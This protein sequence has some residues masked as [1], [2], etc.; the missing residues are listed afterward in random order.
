[1]KIYPQPN[2][3]KEMLFNR[4]CAEIF[5]FDFSTV[6]FSTFHSLC[7]KS[8]ELRVKSEVMVIRFADY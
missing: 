5:C 8:G 6:Y 1:M 7:G 3:Q 4:A 2:V